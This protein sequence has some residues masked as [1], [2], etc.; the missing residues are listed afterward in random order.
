MTDRI[1][2]RPSRHTALIALGSNLGSRLEYLQQAL[3]LLQRQ[4]GLQVSAVSPVY[5][6]NPVGYADQGKFLNAAVR[7]ETSLA[8]E[9]LLQG[10]ME[11]EQQLQRRR[12]IHWGPRTIDL[13]MLFYDQQRISSTDL[14]VP[15][16]RLSERMFVLA[17]LHDIAPMWLHPQINLRVFELFE[18]L[19]LQSS[20]PSVYHEGLSLPA[21][22]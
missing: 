18:Q 11:I 7:L 4:T 22:S 17:P 12:D 5:E 9:T 1:V 15:H 21:G 13:D 3:E 16:P 14:E 10:L 2:R 20:V 19:K 8:P 6:T